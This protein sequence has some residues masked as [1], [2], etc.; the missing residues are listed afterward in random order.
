MTEFICVLF[1]FKTEITPIPAL[2]KVRYLNILL[3]SA[4]DR[5]GLN[6]VD[7]TVECCQL[8]KIRYC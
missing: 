1:E 3:T 8:N 6:I 5:Q 2:S 4:C 7:G